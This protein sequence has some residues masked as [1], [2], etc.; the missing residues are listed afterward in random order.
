MRKLILTSLAFFVVAMTTISCCDY[1]E[2]TDDINLEGTWYLQYLDDR[3]SDDGS[4]KYTFADG[5]CLLKADNYLDSSRNPS[6]YS[7]FRWS[8]KG[9]KLWLGNSEGQRVVMLSKKSKN[10][11][12]WKD[13]SDSKPEKFIKRESGKDYNSLVG[14]LLKGTK[15]V[16]MT[17][18]DGNKT[19]RMCSWVVNFKENQRCSVTTSIDGL[20]CARQIE[21]YCF[22]SP[23]T[24]YFHLVDSNMKEAY[25]GHVEKGTVYL[26]I[27]N[28]QEIPLEI[29]PN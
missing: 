12:Y 7:T 24:S 11:I 13:D 2:D 15:L 3:V 8:L 4:V 27:D 18:N 17:D 21:Y 26:L 22:W 19:E 16:T 28:N 9:D 29:I 5:C 6:T 14:L 1:S 20:F 25:Q 10:E 23:E